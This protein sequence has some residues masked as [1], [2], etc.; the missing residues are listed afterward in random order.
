MIRDL[1]RQV[2]MWRT[3]AMILLGMVIGMVLI[4]LGVMP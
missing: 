1:E 2:F 4:D 3:I